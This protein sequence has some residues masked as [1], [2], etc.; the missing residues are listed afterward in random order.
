MY[1]VIHCVH[2][3]VCVFIF[4]GVY[5]FDEEVLLFLSDQARLCL[6]LCRVRATLNLSIVNEAGYLPKGAVMNVLSTNFTPVRTAVR[7]CD[8]FSCVH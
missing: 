4:L 7:S 2:V 5:E 1:C 6:C 3:C 8:F